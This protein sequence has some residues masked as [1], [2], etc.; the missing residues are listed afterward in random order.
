MSAI[1]R[2]TR[3]HRVEQTRG[4]ETM[5]S[6]GTVLIG[7]IGLIAGVL[8]AALRS[9]ANTLPVATSPVIE[10]VPAVKKASNLAPLNTPETALLSKQDREK[11]AALLEA[12]S[13]PYVV[14]DIPKV[15]LLA[16]RLCEARTEEEVH[17]LRSE[18]SL[19]LQHGHQQV[20]VE[21]LTVAC[22]NAAVRTGFEPLET[23]NAGGGRRMAAVDKS[24]RILVTEVQV[25]NDGNISLATETVN[26]TDGSC[27]GVLD[28]FEQALEREGVRSSYPERKSTGGVCELAAAKKAAMDWVRRKVKPKPLTNSTEDERRRKQVAATAR[29]LVRS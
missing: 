4:S 26:I 27:E 20:L 12:G 11:V 1:S 9:A 23:E 17:L 16:K 13:A 3:V 2:R 24:G 22:R 21:R 8:G 15:Q 6:A 28:S 18:L 29:R 10:N 19:T 5:E 14:H 7:V 25:G